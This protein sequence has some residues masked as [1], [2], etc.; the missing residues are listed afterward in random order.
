MVGYSRLME[1]N[2]SLTLKHLKSHLQEL[3]EPVFAAYHGHIIK[4]MGDGML[5]EFPSVVD[6]VSSA[7]MI[8][9]K[10]TERN[11][12]V[13]VSE[14]II[15]RIGIHLGDIIVEDD[16]IFGEGV[17][18]AARLESM[19]EPGCVNV[20]SAVHDAI[21]NKLPLDF[22]YLGEKNVKNISQPVRTYRVQLADGAELEI[23]E[24]DEPTP[25][26]RSNWL[27]IVLAAIVLVTGGLLVWLQPWQQ[28]AT[29]VHD[30]PSVIHR[31]DSSLPSLVVLPFSNMGGES[32][33]EYFT[34]GITA[35]ITTDL[36]QL[37]SLRV[38]ARQTA[39]TYR[40]HSISAQQ[41]GNELG[42]RYVVEGSIQKEGDQIRINVRLTDAENNYLMWGERFD[43]KLGDIFAVQDEIT[44][45]IVNTLSIEISDE[46]R[47]RL[48]HRYTNSVQA[49]DLF[50]RGQQAYVQQNADDNARAQQFFRRAIGL[51]PLFARAYAALALTYSDDWRFGWSNESEK[52]ADEALR[53]ARRAVA[54]DDNLPQ[55]YWVLGFVHIFRGEYKEAINASERAI[56]LD[57][58]N[59]DAYV[60]LAIS[61][62]FSG[63]PEK[64]IDLMQQA[65]AL[66]PRYGSRY[67][68]VLAIAYYHAGKYQ[69]A[70]AAFNDS[71]ARNPER[72]PP[73]L[74]KTVL[75]MK[76]DRKED[77]EWQVDEVLAIKPEFSLDN[78][79]RILP[80]SDEAERTEFISLLQEAGF[81]KKVNE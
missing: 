46:E 15:F 32:Q 59:S 38:I 20:S 8:Q 41:V 79:D 14:Q 22:K 39:S 58:N 75:L 45:H 62:N 68:G 35:D 29:P 69:E 7:V 47:R 33:N 13:P 49:Y 9:K 52:G 72:I 55:A 5:V 80:F 70:L 19:A 74:Y 61:T 1:E 57:P 56:T 48:A 42:I 24:L 2:E 21:G 81:H 65:I 71:L 23:P 25:P 51:D 37:G 36:S 77:A 78:L 3:I 67:S 76:M 44:S 30:I 60:T 11:L 10:M 12:D 4:R 28:K 27:G 73:H 26:R 66:N 6:A 63:N 40:N 43:R 16:D 54:L 34:E 18:I 53:L 50:L 31:T 17:N 64:A